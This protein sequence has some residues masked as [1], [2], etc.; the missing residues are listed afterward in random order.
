M[1]GIIGFLVLTFI[2][3]SVV[4]F[5]DCFSKPDQFMK[6]RSGFDFRDIWE[7]WKNVK[8]D[9]QYRKE[10]EKYWKRW[11]DERSNDNRWKRY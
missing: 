7:R 2:F 11:D 5:L 6:P 3:L 9:N 1:L 8:A 4:G 10:E